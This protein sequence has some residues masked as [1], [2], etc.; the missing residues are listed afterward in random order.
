MRVTEPE[1]RKT[2][3]VCVCVSGAQDLRRVHTQKSSGQERQRRETQLKRKKEGECVHDRAR[4][5]CVRVCVYLLLRIFGAS[6][7]PFLRPTRGL[8][9]QIG[10]SILVP[11]FICEKSVRQRKKKSGKG[12]A[13]KSRRNRRITRTITG[14]RREE[15]G[16]EE[17]RWD[18]YRV[19]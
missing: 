11:S 18:W 14:S 15:E 4:E 12:E 13:K 3:Y 17:A 2:V 19:I 8:A 10:I 1:R 9:S 7:S 16:E 5:Q 6:T